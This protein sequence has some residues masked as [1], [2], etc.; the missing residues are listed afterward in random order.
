VHHFQK[1]VVETLQGRARRQAPQP[2]P[3]KR[4][5][6]ALGRKAPQRAKPRG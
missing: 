1:M 4:R 3:R 2:A 5:A 6:A